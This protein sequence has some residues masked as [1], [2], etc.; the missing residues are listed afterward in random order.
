MKKKK[1]KNRHPNTWSMDAGIEG[2]GD[3]VTASVFIEAKQNSYRFD[4]WFVKLYVHTTFL[5]F[6]ELLA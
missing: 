2:Q 1:K 6:Q 3:L 5:V 4:W